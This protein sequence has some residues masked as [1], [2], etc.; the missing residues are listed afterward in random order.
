MTKGHGG[1]LQAIAGVELCG[2][3]QFADVNFVGF[4]RPLLNCLHGVMI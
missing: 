2:S 4:N 1:Y 3:C